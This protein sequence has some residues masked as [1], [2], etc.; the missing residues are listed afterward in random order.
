M[1][2]LK[3]AG[4]S[5][6][7][8]PFKGQSKS[9]YDRLSKA[10]LCKSIEEALQDTSDL[11]MDDY[12]R[13]EKILDDNLPSDSGSD[14][15]FPVPTPKEVELIE[16]SDLESDTEIKSRKRKKFFQPKRRSKIP[17]HSSA[18]SPKPSTSS[19]AQQS[20]MPTITLNKSSDIDFEDGDEIPNFS[21][22]VNE[23]PENPKTPCTPVTKTPNTLKTPI[24]SR[25]RRHL[26]HRLQKP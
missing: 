6:R 20:R 3:S 2:I 4:F 24:A 7:K 19:N 8:M 13:Q 14:K 1:K 18:F 23:T 26:V 9:K 15:D 10:E 21:D 22:G 11:E 5:S 12:E 16:E 17:K 25:T